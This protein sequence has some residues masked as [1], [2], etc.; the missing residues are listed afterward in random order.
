MPRLYNK[1]HGFNRTGIFSFTVQIFDFSKNRFLGNHVLFPDYCAGRL[2]EDRNVNYGMKDQL[3]GA[4]G[5]IGM[6]DRGLG[7]S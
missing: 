3:V 5:E 2:G 4:A 1:R 6:G 7:G